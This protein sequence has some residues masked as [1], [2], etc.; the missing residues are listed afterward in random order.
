MILRS[1]KYGA[2]T[3]LTSNSLR[4]KNIGRDYTLKIIFYFDGTLYLKRDYDLK[5]NIYSE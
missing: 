4:A 2:T 1:F 3:I 5:N